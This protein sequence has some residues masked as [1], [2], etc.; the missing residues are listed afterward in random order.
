MN[1]PLEENLEEAMDKNMQEFG[2]DMIETM[3]ENMQ[4][5]DQN[6][7][8]T[9]DENMHHVN[10]SLNHLDKRIGMNIIKYQVF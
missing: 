5:F 4:E 1:G 2:E 3:D 9:M 10:H 8:E 6:M 7:T